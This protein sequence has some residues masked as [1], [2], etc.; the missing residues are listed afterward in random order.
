VIPVEVAG[1]QDGTELNLVQRAQQGNEEA[2][3]TL[4]H[5]IKARLLSLLADDERR[6]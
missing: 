6:R 4:F 2:F 3:A 5:Y 1:K